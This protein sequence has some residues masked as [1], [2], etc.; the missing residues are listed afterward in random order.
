MKY[1]LRILTS[2]ITF[3]IA[4]NITWAYTVNSGLSVDCETF[5]LLPKLK[6]LTSLNPNG[7]VEVRFIKFN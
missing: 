2:L 3:L 4:L 5:C 1:I 6:N 7:E